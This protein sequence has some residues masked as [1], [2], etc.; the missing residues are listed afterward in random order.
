MNEVIAAD[1]EQVAI[2]RVDHH[3]Q[4]RIRELQ[5]GGE[6]DGAAVRRVER[7]ELRIAGH[8]PRAADAGDDSYL[9]QVGLG[10]DQRPGETVDRGADAAART[11]DVRQLTGQSPRR[12][13]AGVDAINHL[14]G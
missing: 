14:K 7:I 13:T 2:A 10:F 12:Q 9:V 11:P 3:L 6:R 4:L 1:R 5:P 8:P